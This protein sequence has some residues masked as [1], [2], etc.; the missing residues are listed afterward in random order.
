MRVTRPY[1]IHLETFNPE[2][3]LLLGLPPTGVVSKNPNIVEMQKTINVEDPWNRGQ[4]PTPYPH[5]FINNDFR[6]KPMIPEKKE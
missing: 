2:R 6:Q 3:P 5:V 1:F 4:Q